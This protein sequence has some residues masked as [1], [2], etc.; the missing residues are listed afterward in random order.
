MAEHLP[1]VVGRHEIAAAVALREL[2]RELFVNEL[3]FLLGTFGGVLD[4]VR[5]VVPLVGE[6]VVNLVPDG[7]AAVGVE[8]PGAKVSSAAGNTR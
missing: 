4:Q 8:A 2:D 1:F 7:I 5:H 6:L 3:P